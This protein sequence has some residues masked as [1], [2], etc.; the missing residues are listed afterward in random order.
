MRIAEENG[1]HST[2][3]GQRKSVN[4]LRKMPDKQSKN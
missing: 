4:G 1:R 3:K 2:A